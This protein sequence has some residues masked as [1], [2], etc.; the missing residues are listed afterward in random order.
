MLRRV[1][2]RRVLAEGEIDVRMGS[3]PV[4]RWWEEIGDW[5][6][7][8]ADQSPEDV[9]GSQTWLL[10]LLRGTLLLRS[11]LL[12]RGLL[13]GSH[14]ESPPRIVNS[15]WRISGTSPDNFFGRRAYT[16][17][18]RCAAR[19][20]RSSQ[21]LARGEKQVPCHRGRGAL[22]KPSNVMCGSD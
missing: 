15:C 12:L 21:G 4:P 22:L 18:T 10:L 16:R 13:L 14:F 8:F 5:P 19:F 7:W 20:P 1:D 9:P 11:A 3:C 2:P 17:H 6:T